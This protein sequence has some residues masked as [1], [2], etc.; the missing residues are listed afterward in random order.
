M[1][2]PYNMHERLSGMRLEE[3]GLH[4]ASVQNHIAHLSSLLTMVKRDI[5]QL[6]EPDPSDH[7]ELEVMLLSSKLG[8]LFE[9]L[10]WWTLPPAL[11]TF[12]DAQ[13]PDT[14]LGL[15]LAISGAEQHLR[16]LQIQR[17]N[18]RQILH[19][20]PDI[21]D[22]SFGDGDIRGLSE[23]LVEAILVIE[24]GDMAS[25]E[26]YPKPSLEEIKRRFKNAHTG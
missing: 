21:Q 15:H 9:Q 25:Q 4:L 5:L 8:E 26:M 18:L 1:K 3:K 23:T 13:L 19:K 2:K 12:E 7:T 16:S 22:Q 14:D 11:T 17:H 24:Y 6:R 20:A 10:E